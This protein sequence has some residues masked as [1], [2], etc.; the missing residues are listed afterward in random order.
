[1]V[2][3]VF[4]CREWKVRKHPASSHAT[5]IIRVALSRGVVRLCKHKTPRIAEPSQVASRPISKSWLA[6]QKNTKKASITTMHHFWTTK[7]QWRRGTFTREMAIWSPR[8]D[9]LSGTMPSAG[10]IISSETTCNLRMKEHRSIHQWPHNDS[11]Y[12]PHPNKNQRSSTSCITPY[13]E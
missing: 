8:A 3:T 13:R 11:W 12:R 1:V 9:S 7:G 10:G 5:A 6:A 2:T 4:R